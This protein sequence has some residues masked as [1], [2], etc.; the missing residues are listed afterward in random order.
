MLL[1]W[2]KESQ[3]STSAL[4]SNAL[5][6]ICDGEEEIATFGGGSWYETF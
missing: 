5:K 4:F 6:S 1:Q 2:C 3:K